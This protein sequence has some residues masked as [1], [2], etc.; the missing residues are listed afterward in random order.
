MQ[1]DPTAQAT[2]DFLRSLGA[3]LEDPELARTP[4]RVSRLWRENLL[5]GEG[6]DPREAL[7]K[8][9]PAS[10]GGVVTL[11]H[12]PFH[13]LC[14]HH[15]LPFFGVAHV[16]Y[17]PQD[18]IVGLGAIERLLAV[19]SRRLIL[20]ETLTRVVAETLMTHLGARGA[21]C[22]LEAT[23]LC[24]SLQGREPHGAR[25]HTRLGLGTLEGRGDVLPPVTA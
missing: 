3:D 23:H 15:L 24:L 6:V 13:G 18:H 19:C 21:A 25:V 8:P 14:P 20:Q 5:S 16:A 7:G 2:V 4:E 11:T 17:A 1:S 12:L 22:A 9:L 10:E